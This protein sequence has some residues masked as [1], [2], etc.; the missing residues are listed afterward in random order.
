MSEA[1]ERTDWHWLFGLMLREKCKD[2][3][4]HV[5]LERDLSLKQQ[6][7]DVLVMRKGDGPLPELPEAFDGLA[8]HN[9]I[10][11][12][13][14]REALDAFAMRELIGHQV[15]YLKQNAPE[16]AARLD[17]NEVR[18]FAVSGRYPEGLFASLT[19]TE[20]RPG[21]YDVDF[22]MLPVRV[23]AAS[24]LDEGARNAILNLFSANAGRV[25]R[26]AVA[27]GFSPPM[28]LLLA[29]VLAKYDW[30]ELTMPKT[31]AEFEAQ[32]ARE[33]RE[34]VLRHMTLEE[35]LEGLVPEQVAEAISD[36]EADRLF[37]ALQRRRAAQKG[38]S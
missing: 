34:L 31:L 33:N 1:E 17:E 13:S 8:A 14:H 7:L 25:K 15:N 10:T 21:V 19:P 38:E 27:G 20:V 4:L 37:E 16:G 35:R 6:F 24:R 23:V 12:K 9:L 30:E 29:R 3:A 5:E 32:I 2:S 26:A 11:F 22:A 36:E 28:N 18:L